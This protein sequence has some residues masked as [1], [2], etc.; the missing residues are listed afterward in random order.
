MLENL[1]CNSGVRLIR[2]IHSKRVLKWASGWCRTA[3]R[4]D[5]V[6]EGAQCGRDLPVPGIIQ[7][8]SFERWRP[9]FQHADQLPRAQEW[10]GESFESVC[11]PQPVNCRANGQ[12][13]IVDHH[14]AIY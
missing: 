3:G 1:M 11:D 13:G 7:V 9:V 8:Q 2:S 6:D 10:L 5:Q 4:P 12:V 14:A